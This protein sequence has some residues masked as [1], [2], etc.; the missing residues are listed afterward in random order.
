M[1]KKTNVHY[2]VTLAL[3][4]ALMLVMDMT[5]LA[6][7]PLPGQYTSIL[8]VP[9]AVGAMLL[10]P[11][12]GAIL[13][14][15]MGGISFATAAKTGFSTLMLAGYTGYTPML[16]AFVNSF[17]PRILMGY[18]VGL[19]FKA[20]YKIDKTK[21]VSYYVGGLLAPLLNTILYMGVLV[22]VFLNAP[23]LEALLSAELMATFRDN[24][25]L[26]VFAYVGIQALLE[27]GLG[28]VISG[29]VGKI[30]HRVLKK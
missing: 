13:G 10:G 28:C 5:G 11:L 27:I 17:L 7:I 16:L 22:I 19:L 2:L 9:V 29:T 12:A 24:I 23:T 20:I 4:T 1:K 8:T 21:T 26:F 15:V 14:G 18:L 3:L 6:M 30:L 25:L